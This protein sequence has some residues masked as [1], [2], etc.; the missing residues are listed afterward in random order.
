MSHTHESCHTYRGV[1]HT[2]ESCHIKTT[3]RRMDCRWALRSRQKSLGEIRLPAP[4]GW[5]LCAGVAECGSVLQCKKSRWNTPAYHSSVADQYIYIHI[6][7]CICICMYVYIHIYV[8]TYISIYVCTY[9][10]VY[11]NH[12]H[13]CIYLYIYLYTWIWIFKNMYIHIYT[14]KDSLHQLATTWTIYRK[15]CIYAYK[16]MYIYIHT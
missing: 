16:Y 7:I 3:P 6:C 4:R 5:H 15:M 11:I 14:S 13:I 12:F 10:H 1:S 9:I 2:Y 8:H